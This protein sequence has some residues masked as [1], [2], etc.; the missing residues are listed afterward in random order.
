MSQ[1]YA[2]SQVRQRC[3]QEAGHEGPHSLTSYWT[4]DECYDPAA[5]L[6]PP[7]PPKMVLMNTAAQEAQAPTDLCFSCECPRILHGDSGC[8]AHGCRTFV[9]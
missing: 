5:V 3:D 6:L 9:D 7:P 2:Y 4:D 1:C 8:E